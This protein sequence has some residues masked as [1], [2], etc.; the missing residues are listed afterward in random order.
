MTYTTY[1]L[2]FQTALVRHL[3]CSSMI[4]EYQLQRDLPPTHAL[5]VCDE[6]M[7]DIPLL[8]CYL[9]AKNN[10]RY[11]K[12]TKFSEF[13]PWWKF[14]SVTGE[15]VFAVCDRCNKQCPQGVVMADRMVP[16]A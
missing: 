7:V 5:K 16:A 8:Q 10:K 2:I 6:A 13:R 1:L 11:V 12:L 3:Q 15:H 9:H 4:N 14:L